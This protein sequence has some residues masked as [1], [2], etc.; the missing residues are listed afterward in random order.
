M[1]L[2]VNEISAKKFGASQNSN[3]TFDK[4]QYWLKPNTPRGL[5]RFVVKRKVQRTS[6][7]RAPRER[8]HDAR[9]GSELTELNTSLEYSRDDG[10]RDESEMQSS[11]LIPYAKLNFPNSLVQRISDISGRAG[12]P[13]RPGAARA[14]TFTSARYRPPPAIFVLTA[15][16]Q[17]NS[18]RAFRRRHGAGASPAARRA[19]ADTCAARGR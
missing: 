2:A 14:M 4:N 15:F 8:G 5:T 3:I 9:F 13:S 18:T 19:G 1:K 12:T 6:P 10:D 17:I 16:D 7:G 11:Y